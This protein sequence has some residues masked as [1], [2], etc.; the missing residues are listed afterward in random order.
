MK[1]LVFV[2]LVLTCLSGPVLAANN[3]EDQFRYQTNF[4][5][6]TDKAP[7]KLQIRMD[8]TGTI[9]GSPIYVGYAARGTDAAADSWRVYKFTDSAAGPTLRQSADCAWDDRAG[10]C[11]YA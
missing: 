6:K 4:A 5:Q 3:F 8:Y 2:V 9:S 1:K 7:N 11:V 10:S